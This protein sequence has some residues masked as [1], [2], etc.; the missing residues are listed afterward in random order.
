MINRSRLS[1][2]ILLAACT[3]VGTLF[4][5][6]A[7]NDGGKPIFQIGQFD[8]DDREFALA[9]GNYGGFP[10]AF[11]NGCRFVVGESDPA[12]D[13]SFIHPGPVDAW[14]NSKEWPFTVVF[15]VPEAPA[16]GEAM[17]AV[18]LIGA[19]PGAPPVLTV[20]LNG[21]GLGTLE[22]EAGNNMPVY[23]DP[24]GGQEEV[25]RLIFPATQIKAGKNELTIAAGGGS[26]VVYDALSL[27][28]FPGVVPESLRPVDK[29][30]WAS[31]APELLPGVILLNSGIKTEAERTL[32]TSLQ[33]IVNKESARL[34]LGKRSDFWYTNAV[35]MKDSYLEVKK[36]LKAL[37]VF[38]SEVKGIIVVDPAVPD[39]T[40]VA[41]TLASLKS[42]VVAV[43]ELVEKL[44]AAPYNFPVIKDLRGMFKNGLEAYTW[45]FENLWPEL[46]HAAVANINPV[47]IRMQDYMMAKKVML[48]YLST[49]EP[50]ELKLLE[51]IYGGLKPNSPTY[52]WPKDGYDNLDLIS[53][54]GGYLVT[55]DWCDNLTVFDKGVE[56]TLA[57]PRRKLEKVDKNKVYVAFVMS[58][59][60]IYHYNQ[61]HMTGLWADPARGRVPIGWT[62]NPLMIEM[63]PGM[64]NYYYE[65]ATDNDVF[66]GPTNLLGLGWPNK[67]PNLAGLVAKAK[68]F[69]QRAGITSAWISNSPEGISNTS[70]LAE[71]DLAALKTIGK[72]GYLSGIFYDYADSPKGPLTIAADGVPVAVSLASKGG[73]STADLA[74][75]IVATA[76]ERGAKFV[77]VGLN[78]WE[79]KPGRVV[80][81]VNMLGESKDPVFAVVRPDEFFSGLKLASGK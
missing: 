53:G 45:A 29:D 26:W 57:Q 51:R 73:E 11:P 68:P 75:R 38:K 62:I 43:P 14:A 5:A 46:S 3:L 41:Y 55:S 15:T 70:S 74:K 24:A 6:F 71:Q 37:E 32:M 2:V 48:F 72:G 78:S 17:L 69:Y 81:V 30:P 31:I 59:G 49:K 52:G 79:F 54:H 10:G 16:G 18:D 80:E 8:N 12:K 66:V 61:F 13:W 50:A 19:H 65:T 21:A 44:T 35:A 56:P 33:G 67:N 77:F 47:Q 39:T 9:P 63:A 60:G 40:N 58:N 25:L 23:A 76:K 4:A 20:A 36:P 42:A 27:Q 28:V 1:M 64:I 7:G 34:Y 22:P